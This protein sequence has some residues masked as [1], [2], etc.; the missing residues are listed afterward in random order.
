MSRLKED[1]GPKALG[2]TATQTTPK[3]PPLPG[4]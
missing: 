4:L 2:D 1:Q 3:C